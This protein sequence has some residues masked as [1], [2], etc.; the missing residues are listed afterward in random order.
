MVEAQLSLLL[1]VGLLTRHSASHDRY[2]FAMPNA[3]PLVRSIAAG[4]KV[5]LLPS[6]GAPTTPN[7]SQASAE[8]L[9]A[10]RST[11][12]HKFP[13]RLNFRVVQQRW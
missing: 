12:F 9:K 7:R 5:T 3:G 8:H 13:Y 11:P 4:R 2:L 1:N 10:S 6:V